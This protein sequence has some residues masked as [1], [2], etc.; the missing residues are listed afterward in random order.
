VRYGGNTSCVEVRTASGSVIILDAGTGIRR[1]GATLAE[2]GRVDILLSHLHTD[3]IQG[4]GFFAPLYETDREVH[5]WGPRSAGMDLRARLTRYLSAPLF[6]VNL[7]E[8]P[9]RLVLHDAPLGEFEVGGLRIRTDLVLHPGPTL[10]Y[11]V[12][13]V[14]ATLVYLSDHEPALGYAR[15]PDA[16]A[17]TSGYALAQGADLLIHDSQY[18]DE[19]YESHAGWGHSS[20]SQAIAFGRLAG[21]RRLVTFHH[22]PG[23]SDAELDDLHTRAKE[24]VDRDFELIPGAEGLSIP[25]T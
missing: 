21:V 19:E 25:V 7:R 18:T 10:G 16:A 24:R 5:I 23:H 4:L 3:H 15:L 11:R 22:D 20:M 13:E 9:S 1:L 2:G 12:S 8:L 17:W 6:P 14:G